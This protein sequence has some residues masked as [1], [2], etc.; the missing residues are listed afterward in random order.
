MLPLNPSFISGG[1]LLPD[2][3]MVNSLQWGSPLHTPTFSLFFKR[4]T[5]LARADTAV[6]IVPVELELWG[7]PAHAWG[8]STVQR[9]LSS[10]CCM[11]S[12]H[13]DT[14]AQRSLCVSYYGMVLMSGINSADGFHVHPRP[15]LA[16]GQAAGRETRPV[17]PGLSDGC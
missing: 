15:C 8:L 9:V 16:R 1:P 4:W 13:A 12:L 7:I 11:Q 10:T 14:A 3:A 5:R 2:E 17:V 6:L